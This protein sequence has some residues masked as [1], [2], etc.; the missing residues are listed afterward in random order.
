MKPE[1]IAR[2]TPAAP[3]ARTPRAIGA[4]LVDAGKLS[5]EDAERVMKLQRD[6]NL[7]FGDAALKLNVLK[8]S[9]ID[10]A[11][12]RQ[13]SFDYLQRGSSPVSETVVAAYDPFNPQVEPFR[14]LR[15][16]VILRWLDG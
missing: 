6:E 2:W 13:F 9:D 12:S 16:Q 4:I 1:N 8:Q 14:T 10:F 15:S 7:R 11:L 3:V 5:V